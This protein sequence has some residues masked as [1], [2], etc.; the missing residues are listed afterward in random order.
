MLKLKEEEGDGGDDYVDVNTAAFSRGTTALTARTAAAEDAARAA[1][2]AC[3]ASSSR[4]GADC[5][6]RVELKVGVV[7]GDKDV[8]ASAAITDQPS[9]AARTSVVAP[10]SV[11]KKQPAILAIA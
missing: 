9:I 3:T 8:A 11:A 4:G 10:A 2:A 7:V 1:L 6:G 5:L